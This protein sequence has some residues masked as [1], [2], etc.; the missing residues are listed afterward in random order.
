[1]PSLEKS[2]LYS[3]VREPSGVLSFYFS[4]LKIYLFKSYNNVLA[5]VFLTSPFCLHFKAY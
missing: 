4:S 1:M 5:N 2:L 3:F